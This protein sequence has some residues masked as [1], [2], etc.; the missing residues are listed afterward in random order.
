MET[1][2]EFRSV[3]LP[4]SFCP[5]G[6]I[7]NGPPTEMKERPP[8]P[9]PRSALDPSELLATSS[10]SQFITLPEPLMR[11]DSVLARGLS[12]AHPPAPMSLI[13]PAATPSKNKG[14]WAA[15]LIGPR[16]RAA[17]PSHVFPTPTVHPP[18][19]KQGKLGGDIDRAPSAGP[20]FAVPPT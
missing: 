4:H 18:P 3:P 2:R 12:G 16:G 17:Y 8:P 11:G 20:R 9:A 13:P 15:T 6:R 1:V 5:D 14:S 10:Q 19:E 7:A